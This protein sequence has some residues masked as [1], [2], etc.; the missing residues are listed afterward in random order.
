[1]HDKNNSQNEISAEESFLEFPCEFPIKIIGKADV[2]CELK[3]VE[4][5]R[6]HA[7]LIDGSVRT[8]PSRNQKYLA[9]TV[10][11]EAHSRPQLDSIY[12]EFT[13]SDWVV[14]AL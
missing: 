11:I 9:V 12:Q 6:R 10:T 14:W 3:A 7:V 1:M 2:P 4:I 5:I 13:D 8:R